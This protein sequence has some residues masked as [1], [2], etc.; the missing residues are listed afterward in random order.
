MESARC[1]WFSTSHRK[2]G[3]S[4]YQ[5]SSSCLI[6]FFL[7]SH[8]SVCNLQY[9]YRHA[10][11]PTSMD[12]YIVTEDHGYSDTCTNSHSLH[13]DTYLYRH[14]HTQALTEGQHSEA[15][16][17]C[18]FLCSVSHCPCLFHTSCHYVPSPSLSALEP[19]LSADNPEKNSGP[20]VC[21]WCL[22]CWRSMILTDCLT[23]SLIFV[24]LTG[25][26]QKNL[27]FYPDW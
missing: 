4:L 22:D 5:F 20:N 12:T 16:L 23:F 1:F 14:A 15:N 27:D 21:P 26:Y 25:T 19:V 13:T 2:I 8:Y 17:I 10:G 18:V 24:W 7:H 9:Q 6:S 11:T 3:A